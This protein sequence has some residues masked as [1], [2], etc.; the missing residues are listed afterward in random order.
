MAEENSY[1]VPLYHLNRMQL[2]ILSRK[3]TKTSQSEESNFTSLQ[4]RSHSLERLWHWASFQWTKAIK[5]EPRAA[6]KKLHVALNYVW[7]YHVFSWKSFSETELEYF[8]SSFI[9]C[10]F[11]HSVLVY[12]PENKLLVML[13]SPRFERGVQKWDYCCQSNKSIWLHNNL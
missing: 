6:W 5:S 4:D 11:R 8:L 9:R 2:C 12:S 1:C 13:R 10:I 3:H 7:F